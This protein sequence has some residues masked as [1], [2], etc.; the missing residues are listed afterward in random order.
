[1]L[2]SELFYRI[3]LPKDKQIACGDREQHSLNMPGKLFYTIS[4]KRGT[5][6]Q[7]YLHG[8]ILDQTLINC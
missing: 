7:I 1:M 6:Q 2:T 4:H 5:R 3:D 8:S